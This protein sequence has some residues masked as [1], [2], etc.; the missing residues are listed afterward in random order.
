MNFGKFSVNN[1][2]LINILMVSL[3]VLGALSLSR[4]PREQ[5]SEVP[6]FWVNIAVP[7]PG[8][9]AEDVEKSVTVK[10]ENEME[11]LD[12]LDEIVSITQEGL[13]IVRVEFDSGI[14]NDEFERLYQEVQTRFSKVDLPDGTLAPLVDDF[15][16]SDFLPVVEV[17]LA[18]NVEYETLN[19]NARLLRERLLDIPEVADAELVGARD[20]QIII[21]ANREKLEALG[22]SMDE[23]VRA[24]SSRNVTIPGGT[25]ETRS[26]EYLLRTVGEI[27][28]IG[29]FEKVIVRRSGAAGLAGGQSGGPPPGGSQSGVVHVADVATV[30]EVFDPTGADARF[31]MQQ[32]I[33]LRV[34]KVTR[35]NSVAVVNGVKEVVADFEKS[36]PQ[37]MTITLFGDSTVQIRQSLDVLV[38]NALLGL[39]FLV[40]ILLLFIGVRNALIIALGI[41]V[42]FAITFVLLELLGETFNTNTLFALVLVLGLIVDHAIVIIENSFRLNQ[43][44]LSRIDAAIQGTNQVVVPVIAATLTT[45]AAFLPLMILPGTIGRFLR[46]IPLTV[47]IALIASTMEAIVFLPVHFAEW[48][49]NGRRQPGIRFDRLRHGFSRLIDRVYRRRYLLVAIMLVVMIGTFALVGTLQQDLF[50]S[51]DFTLFYIDIELPAGSPK[52]KT[53]SVVAEYE[54]RIMPLLGQGEIISINSSIGFSS[55]GTG[56]EIKSNIAQ[57]IVDIIEKDEGR[58]RPIVE[59]MQEVRQLTAPVPGIESVQFRRAQNGPPVEPPV[60]FRLF[61]DDYG[62]LEVIAAEIRQVLGEYPE[63]Y[64]I[65]DNL[66]T[67]TPELRVRV[68]QDRAAALGLST[69]AIGS[70][71]RGSFEGITATTVFVGNEEIDVIVRYAGNEITSVQQLLQLKIPSPDGRLIPFSTVASVEEARAL[72]AI[73]R[74]D[75]K[76]EV[77]VTS[78]AY[79]DTRVRMINARVK[80]LF[81]DSFQPLYPGVSLKVGGEFAEFGNLLTQILRIFLLGVFLIYLILGTQF[82]SY[83]QPA[84]ILVTVPFAFVG[85]VLYLFVSGTPFSTTVLY[86]GVALAGIAVNDSIVLVSYVNGLKSSGKTTAEAVAEGTTTRLRPILLTSLTTIAGLLP[87]ALGLG[88]KSVVWGPMASTIIF[89]LVFSTIT[90]LFIIPS[91]YGILEDI[92]D[93]R[94]RGKE[95]RRE[96]RKIRTSRKESTHA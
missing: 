49:G 34:T 60:S 6:F 52:S 67:G 11:G 65:G 59:I 16:S 64:N 7:Y 3:L 54:R 72:A 68:N 44:G 42:T 47:S 82:K 79:D 53:E 28:R 41:P 58:T 29:E 74:V 4:L 13:S 18:G 89:G 81:D 2:V 63:L 86:A 87:T 5:F 46:V 17:I 38:N 75:G 23:V 8:V 20:R 24:V 12:K 19:N 10:I 1:S 88:G 57:I 62:Q 78:E 91:L 69:A 50:S 71:I 85:V 48:S 39:A 15:S 33:G 80:R 51:E 73:R 35:G 76:R 32:A 43:E 45:V 93:R 9:S 90:A 21:G 40:G 92:R 94:S 66:E 22:I 37:A 14:S 30:K 77:T 95:R 31:N 36:L 27:E 26:R 56:V 96:K 25:L 55:T 84:L 83:L 61:G 70:F